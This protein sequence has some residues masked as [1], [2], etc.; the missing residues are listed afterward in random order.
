MFK[1][2][3]LGFLGLVEKCSL[4]WLTEQTSAC[5]LMDFFTNV[6]LGLTGLF[7]AKYKKYK[8]KPTVDFSTSKIQYVE[9]MKGRKNYTSH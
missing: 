4:V 8:V 2:K 1:V 9:Q 5:I 3:L 7:T 6:T